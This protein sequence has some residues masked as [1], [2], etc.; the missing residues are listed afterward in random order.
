MPLS[1]SVGRKAI[2]YGGEN[3]RRSA[4]RA[5]AGTAWKERSERMSIGGAQSGRTSLRSICEKASAFA[6]AYDYMNALTSLRPQ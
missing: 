5:S 4:I 2:V 1:P 6:R 3:M